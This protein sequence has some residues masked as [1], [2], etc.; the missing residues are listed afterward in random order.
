MPTG[1]EV[2]LDS[3]IWVSGLNWRGPHEMLNLARVG[4]IELAVSEAILEEVSRI[5]HDRLGCG[6]VPPLATKA[7]SRR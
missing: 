5:L 1:V 4:Q 2:S 6:Q 7:L 3:N